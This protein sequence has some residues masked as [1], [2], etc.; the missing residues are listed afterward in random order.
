[1]FRGSG[2]IPTLPSGF[3]RVFPAY[4]AKFSDGGIPDLSKYI[5][6]L[7]RQ[8]EENISLSRVLSGFQ[9]LT[10]RSSGRGWNFISV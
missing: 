9:M 1:L 7:T 2:F 8:N 10:V 3:S 6:L 4:D 5:F